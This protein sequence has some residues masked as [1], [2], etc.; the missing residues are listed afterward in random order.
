M[1]VYVEGYKVTSHQTLRMIRPMAYWR[2]ALL[3][4]GA[5]HDTSLPLQ[6]K[7]KQKQISKLYP[8]HAKE[9]EKNVRKIRINFKFCTLIY[10]RCLFF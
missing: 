2:M 4:R 9:F 6:L 10:I 5:R 1:Y 3:P 7:T 8:F